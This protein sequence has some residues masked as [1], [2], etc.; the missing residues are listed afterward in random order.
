M[1]KAYEKPEAKKVSFQYTNV[2]AT[3]GNYCDQ[4]WI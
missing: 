2:V 3:L 1:K 4:G